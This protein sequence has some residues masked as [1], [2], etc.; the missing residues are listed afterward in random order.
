MVNG[1]E[2]QGLFEYTYKPE[3]AE[4]ERM[5]ALAPRLGGT[6]AEESS[7]IRAPK[8]LCDEDL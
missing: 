8:Y 4:Y 3:A 1:K 5:K 2:K 6:L 7:K